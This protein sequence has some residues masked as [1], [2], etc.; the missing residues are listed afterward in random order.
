MTRFYHADEDFKVL[1]RNRL[2]QMPQASVK[3]IINCNKKDLIEL[4]LTL[5][6]I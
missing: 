3:R 2:K 6:S 5:K 4:V 1:Q